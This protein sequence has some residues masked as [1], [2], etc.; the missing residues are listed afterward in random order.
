LDDTLFLN[1]GVGVLTPGGKRPTDGIDLAEDK[2][3]DG[4]AFS[5]SDLSSAARVKVGEEDGS[6][7]MRGLVEVLINLLISLTNEEV[8]SA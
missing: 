3:D 4:L 7:L 1:I 8:R 5:Q 2:R 6:S